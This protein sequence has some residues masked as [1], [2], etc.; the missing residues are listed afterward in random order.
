MHHVYS[1]GGAYTVSQ[2]QSINRGKV[3]S[4]SNNNHHNN[5]RKMRYTSIPG[6]VLTVTS[7][8]EAGLLR[9]QKKG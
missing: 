9:F 4:S 3:Y 7:P 8:I 6:T 5:L 2:N 1:P